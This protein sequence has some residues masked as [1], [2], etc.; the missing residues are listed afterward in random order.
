MFLSPSHPTSTV[1][2]DSST[3]G[4]AQDPSSINATGPSHLSNHSQVHTQAKAGQMMIRVTGRLMTGPTKRAKNKH[5]QLGGSPP[6][7]SG[8]E[9]SNGGGSDTPKSCKGKA[10]A[11]PCAMIKDNHHHGHIPGEGMQ[12][13]VELGEHTVVEADKIA[14]EYGKQCSTILK[15]AGLS[16]SSTQPMSDWN[17]YQ[18]WY[19]SKHPKDEDVDATTYH[20]QMKGHFD[21]HKDE[22]QI[23]EI[24]EEVHKHALLCLTDTTDLKPAQVHNLIMKV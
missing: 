16:G 11:C 23:P 17:Y 22:E 12:K 19:A 14:K 6:S 13:A 3:I 18:V 24:W 15:L 4:L 10:V 9:A 5:A 7:A 20:Q 2:N 1:T 21:E 8:T